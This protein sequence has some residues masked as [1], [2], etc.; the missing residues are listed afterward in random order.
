MNLA[1]RVNYIFDLVVTIVLFLLTGLSI[2]LG[3][4]IVFIAC[5]VDQLGFTEI[6]RR[7]LSDWQT[8]RIGG[9]VC[10]LLGIAL[11]WFLSQY[12]LEDIQRIIYNR[13]VVR[14]QISTV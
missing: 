13:K 1:D 9:L 12:F 7:D 8:I 14:K 5:L 11:G 10:S 6:L 4:T 2:F 3:S